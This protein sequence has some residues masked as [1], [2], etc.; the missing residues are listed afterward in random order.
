[1]LF[2][3]YNSFYWK[4]KEMWFVTFVLFCSFRASMSADVMEK[5]EI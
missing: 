1:M 3:L 5:K 4:M 2:N